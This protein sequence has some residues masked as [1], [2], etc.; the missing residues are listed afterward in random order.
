MSAFNAWKKKSADKLKDN[1]KKLK[2]GDSS[3]GGDNR[4]YRPKPDAAGEADVVL[5][6]LPPKGE[7][8]P[9]VRI[10]K[11]MINHKGKFFAIDCPSTV[12]QSCPIC[13]KAREY[14]NRDDKEN[15]LKYYRKKQYL[16]NVYIIKDPNQPEFEG[17]TLVYQ[18]GQKIYEK[19]MAAFAPE[20]EDVEPMDIFDISEGHDFK[21][22]IGDV[23]GFRNYDKSF[24]LN[25]PTELAGGDEKKLEEIF[26]G[27]VELETLVNE[28]VIPSEDEVEKK[29]KAFMNTTKVSGSMED[30][31]DEPRKPGKKADEE[32]PSSKPKPK[33]EVEEDDD[34]DDDLDALLEGDDDDDDI[35]F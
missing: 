26:E 6:F 1:M 14:F 16:A 10:F 28:E 4:F 8:M 25:K 13:E 5:R 33:A 19:I 24:F 35:P 20:D 27:L 23:G 34:D 32:K 22:K 11:H 29:F 30:S 31:E 21:L 9:V 3:G 2:D 12:G 17:K 18:F 15:G 7:G